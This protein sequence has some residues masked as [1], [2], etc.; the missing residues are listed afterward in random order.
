MRLTFLPVLLSIAVVLAA[1][2]AP[3][4]APSTPPTPAPATGDQQWV[5]PRTVPAGMGS[6]APDGVFPRTVTHF[7]G[8]TEIPA[9]PL[10]VVVLSTGQLDGLLALG[11]TPVGTTIAADV[12]TPTPRYLSEAFPD[13]ADALATMTVLGLRD[14]PNLEAIARVDPDLILGN[15]AGVEEFY[16]A[17]SAIAPT[18]LT[19]GTGVNWKQ[20]FLLVA[21]ALGRAQQAQQILDTFATDAAALGDRAGGATTV[22]FLR[23]TGD[24]IRVYGVPSFTGSIAQDAGLPR[25]PAQTF[26]ST[27]QDISTEEL[28]KGDGGRLFYG[29]QGDAP[30]IMGSELWKRI[31]AVAEGRAV[32]VDDDAW[33]LNAG[34]IAARLVLRGM[35][36][37]LAR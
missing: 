28:A 30:E 18:V 25:P 37:A 27:S 3:A 29:V 13:R 22:S 7:G 14:S 10:R 34:P 5:A 23:I 6:P 35:E 19:Q 21:H 20:D 9:A 1:C 31:P 33:Y 24:R 12:V 11:V 15:K 2:G 4:A 32:R 36:D 17:L 26:T 8:V 16:P